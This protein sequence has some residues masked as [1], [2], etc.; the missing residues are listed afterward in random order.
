M[1]KRTRKLQKSDRLRDARTSP[2]RYINAYYI[3]LDI[4]LVIIVVLV[5]TIVAED[6]AL[7]LKGATA[8]VPLA[9]GAAPQ[10]S[11]EGEKINIMK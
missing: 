9:A 6:I 7:A 8:A 2:R 10:D 11:A 1:V 5:A 4:L 3:I